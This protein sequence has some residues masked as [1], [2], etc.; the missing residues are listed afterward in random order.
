MNEI[1][2]DI[3]GEH[4]TRKEVAV[5]GLIAPLALIAACVVAELL[6]R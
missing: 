2:A 5:Y 4:F 6:N 3:K 1:I